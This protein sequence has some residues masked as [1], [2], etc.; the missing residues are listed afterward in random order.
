MHPPGTNPGSAGTALNRLANETSPYLLQHAANPVDWYPW[1]EQALE[2]ARRENKPILLSIGYS[3]CHWCHVMA[4]ESFEDPATAAVMNELF[5]NIKVDRE[6]R[7]DLDRIYQ[8]AH[9]MLIQRGGGWPLTMFLSPQD[10]R[11]FFGGTYFPNQPRYGMPGFVDLLHRVAEFYRTRTDDIAQQGEALQRAFDEI[12]P[13]PAGADVA[14]TAEPI[15]VA[16]EML[17][18]EFDSHFGGFGGAPKFPHPANIAFLLRTWRASATSDEPD[19]HA[20]YMATLTLTRMAEG[21]LYD[22]LAGGFARYSVDQYW[23]IPHFE[24]MLYDNGQLLNVAAQAAIA[25]GDPLFRR[26]AGETADWIIRDMQSPAGGYWSTLDADSEGHEGKFYVWDAAAVRELLPGPVYDVLARRF[27]LDQPANFEGLWHL[28]VYRP[29]DEIAAELGIAIESAE[30]RLD[31][32]RR[33]LLAVRD[34]R[35]WPGRDEKVLTSWNGLAISAMAVAARTL[36]RT[37]LADSAT[38][39]VDFIHSRLWRSGRLLA[40]HKDGQSRFP[41]YL[42]DYAFLLDGLLELL[43]TRWRSQD[44]QLAIALAEALLQHFED[45]EHGGFFFTADDH[46]QLIH[47]SRS[48]ADEAIPAGNAVAAQGLIRLG[49]LLGETRFLDAAARTLRASWSQ[50]ERY[51]H[52]HAT[53]LMALEE[54]LEAPHIIIIRGAEAAEWRDELAVAYA[55]RR[56]IFAIPAETTDLPP[57]LADKKALDN[58]VAYVCRGMTCSEPLRSLAA[59]AAVI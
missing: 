25:T 19:L 46:E 2:R 33:I 31:E 24:K 27:G 4:H 5:V 45:H 56:L 11:P 21:G 7:P 55:P 26:V 41:A 18:R 1:N 10:Q 47:R 40:V 38:R 8:L 12:A 58:T 29:M 50:L 23:M 35:V 42:D 9:Q 3:A 44:L 52:G 51:P 54:Y 30:Q 59:L 15:V 16:R 32:G 49:L 22:Q 17:A 43:Q 57:A 48:F 13:P 28:H 34:Q 36:K 53:L 37:D 6:E 14:L 20:L 39:A